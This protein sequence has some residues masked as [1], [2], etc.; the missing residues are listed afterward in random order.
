MKA[1]DRECNGFVFLPEKFPQISKQGI[2]DG[3]QIREL[4]KDPMFY[5][6]LSEAELSV[7]Q[8]LKSIV[9]KILVNHLSAE[10][11]KDIEEIRKSFPSTRGTNVSQTAFSA[12]TLGQF[13]K[14][15]WRFE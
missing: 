12:V 2:F 14:E 5:K 1:T 10:H 6:A 13:S 7:W 9:T 3:P 15:L 8:S 4:M 11:E